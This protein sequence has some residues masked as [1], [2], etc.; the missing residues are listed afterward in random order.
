MPVA[1]IS[2]DNGAT[3]APATLDGKKTK[4]AWARWSF[5]WTPTAP[6][7]YNLMARAT[8]T[9]KSTQPATSPFNNGGYI[10]DAVVKHPVTVS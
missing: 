1:D 2:V 10:F 4:G 7:S 5:E 6:G 9:S 3:W 8:D